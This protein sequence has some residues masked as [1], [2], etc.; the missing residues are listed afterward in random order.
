LIQ[1]TTFAYDG[2]GYASLPS[3]GVDSLYRDG[4]TRQNLAINFAGLSASVPLRPAP[5]AV[6]QAVEYYYAAWDHYFITTFADEIA[7]LDAGAFNGNWKRTGESFKVWTQGSATTPAACRFFSSSFAPKSSHFYTPFATECA[8]VKQSSDWQFEGVAFY[9]Q[10]PSPDGT[11]PAGSIPLY[12]LYNNGMGGAP[13]H[14]YTTSVTTLDQMVG[15][16]WTFE[17]NGITKVFACVPE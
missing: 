16:G 6:A 4:S 5:S 10:P 12:R 15:A 7:A 13:N 3:N 9:M 1:S 2:V 11:C 8:T 17:G 14:R